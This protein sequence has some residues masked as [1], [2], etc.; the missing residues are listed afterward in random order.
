M[1][2]PESPDH[3]SVHLTGC[4]HQDAGAV[5]RALE[6]AFPEG[7]GEPRSETKEA[8]AEHPM[9]WCMVV[10]ARTRRAPSKATSVPLA[11]TV[12]VDLFGAADPVR[13]VKEELESAFI[14]EGRGTVPGEHELEVRLRLTPSSA[15]A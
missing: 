15:G 14:V 3:V 9:I 10:D 12:D 4:R 1:S 5:F 11:G 13:Q 7:A 8:G 2:G 6:T